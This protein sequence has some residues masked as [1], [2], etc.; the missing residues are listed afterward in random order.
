MGSSG[1]PP[2]A[3]SWVD[4]ASVVRHCPGLSS[5]IDG[6]TLAR[7]KDSVSNIVRIDA[8]T[9]MRSQMHFQFTMYGKLFGKSLPFEVIKNILLGLW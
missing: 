9:S 4:I 8:N 2:P 3:P 7:L 1:E 5:L 6:A